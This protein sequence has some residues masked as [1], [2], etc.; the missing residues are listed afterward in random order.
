MLSDPDE[1]ELTETASEDLARLQL[2]LARRSCLVEELQ[3]RP[4]I[5]AEQTDA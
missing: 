5:S 1:S 3:G 4:T 2:L